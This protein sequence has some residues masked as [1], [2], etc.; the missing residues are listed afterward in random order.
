MTESS[1]VPIEQKQVVFYEDMI[2]AVLIEANSRQEI[3]V[4]IRQVCDYLG[5]ALK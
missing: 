4:P 5:L 3:Y 1:L 2:T